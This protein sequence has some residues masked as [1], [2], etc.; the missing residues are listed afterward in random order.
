MKNKPIKLPNTSLV[1]EQ[2]K[3][4]NL[5]LIASQKPDKLAQHIIELAKVSY[6]TKTPSQ[7]QIES[8]QTILDYDL[9][10]E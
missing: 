2:E 10:F 7:R 5:Y 8:I 9:G 1:V 6:K 4:P 3:H